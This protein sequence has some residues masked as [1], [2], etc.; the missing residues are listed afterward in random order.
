MSETLSPFHSPRET[1]DPEI[2]D[3][4][5]IPIEYLPLFDGMKGSTSLHLH[6]LPALAHFFVR[7]NQIMIDTD[8]AGRWLF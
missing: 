1:L 5:V 7:F 6:A 8:D 3:R 4:I 2:L